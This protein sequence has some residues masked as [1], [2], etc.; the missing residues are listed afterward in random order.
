[1]AQLLTLSIVLLS[2][3]QGYGPIGPKQWTATLAGPV[4]YKA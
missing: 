2:R 1:M 4:H 3:Q